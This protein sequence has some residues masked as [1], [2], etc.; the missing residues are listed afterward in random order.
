EEYVI[1]L[2]DVDEQGL[3]RLDGAARFLQDVATDDWTDTG[4]VSDDTW[5]VRRTAL[6]LVEGGRWPRYLDR[7]GLTT[8]CGGT[9][10]AWAERRTNLDF[11][12]VLAMEAAALWVPVDPSGHPV[13]MRGSFYAVYG[14]QARSRK[15][16]GRVSSPPIPEDAQRR[17][18]VLR[19]AD[20]DIIGHVNNAAVWQAVSE[21]VKA[22]VREVSVTHHASIER[23]DEVT[24]ITAPGAVWLSVKGVAKVSAQ[25]GDH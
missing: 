7:V 9:G 11:D 2:G 3:L 19:D 6:R 12:G 21:V 10:A 13:R 1:R 4:V 22:P 8:W 25:Y 16:S 20:L 24:L 15:V 5:V 17:P 18:W 14:E 23:D